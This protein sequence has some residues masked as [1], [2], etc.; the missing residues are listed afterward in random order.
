MNFIVMC[1]NIIL[2]IIVM[3]NN[4]DLF[5]KAW[6][7]IV[8]YGFCATYLDWSTCLIIFQARRIML[9]YLGRKIM[10]TWNLVIL[11]LHLKTMLVLFD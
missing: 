6:N 5:K 9:L 1:N 11:F 7:F 4:I 2:L 10:Y 3:C 8:G